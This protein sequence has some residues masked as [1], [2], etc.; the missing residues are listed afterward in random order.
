MRIAAQNPQF[1]L[2]DDFL[3]PEAFE[4]LWRWFQVAPFFNN[5]LR[6]LTGA[7]RL[8]DGRVMRGPDIYYGAVAGESVQD[9]L[10]SASLSGLE[11]RLI[12][13]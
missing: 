4:M 1:L 8:D 3:D 10:C 12:D 9:S 6:G 5:D 2:L 11:V 7:W 13:G